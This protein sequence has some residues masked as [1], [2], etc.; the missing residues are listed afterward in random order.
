MRIVVTGATGNVGTAVLHALAADPRVDEIVGLAR[1]PARTTFAGARL[2]T[3]DVTRDDLATHLA[4]ADV[5]V[6]LAWLFQPTHRPTVTWN[7]NVLGSIR[8]FEAAAAAGVSALVH[9]SSIGAYSAAP[10][11][12]RPVDESWPTH[13]LPTSAYGREKAYVER[14]LDAF[15]LR[16]PHLRVVRMRPAFIFQE[17]AATEQRRLF[18][19]PLFPGALARPGRVPL[20]PHPR[21]LRLQAVHADDIARA[22]VLAALESVHGAFNVAADDVV[23]ADVLAELLQ[24]RPVPV[25]RR[26]VR[27]ALA[28]GWHARL[29]PADPTLFDLFV[30]LPLM[31]TG[32]ARR[33]LGWSPATTARDAIASLLDGL[34]RGA[35][36][37]TPPLAADSPLRRLGELATGVGQ[38]P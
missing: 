36:G 6:H 19:G 28:A 20:L 30:Q 2:V 12:D 25:P 4:G 5:V 27:T 9:A 10:D 23:T 3:A 13:S 26:V 34:A 14:V 18:L 7:A 8:V 33:E 38:R 37:V 21:D 29:V 1:R 15:E 16:H 31:E 17:P 32:R 22:Y 35:G 24:A 11:D